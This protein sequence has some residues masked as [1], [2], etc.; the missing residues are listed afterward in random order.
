M[1][2]TGAIKVNGWLLYGH[3]LFIAQYAQLI[4]Q[5]EKLKQK[6]PD[7]YRQ[8]K[9]AKLLAAIHKLAFEAIPANPTDTIYRQGQTLGKQNKHWF[10]A[11][12]FQ[13][14]RLFFRYDLKHKIIVYVW[15]N[16]DDSKRAYQSKTDAYAVFAK[17][18]A[19]GNPP[20]SWQDLLAASRAFSKQER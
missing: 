20:D 13:Q 14:Y 12:F 4:E 17:M 10:R 9:P 3:E 1:S 8:S 19:N 18:L 16:D 5:V 2:T 15:V 11:K 6:N 7:N